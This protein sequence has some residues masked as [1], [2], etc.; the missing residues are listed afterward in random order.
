[1]PEEPAPE[2][3]D[4]L[5][6]LQ[7][8]DTA[9][10]RLHHQL[11][12][13]PEQQALDEA[14]QRLADLD[15][16]HTEARL[17]LEQAEAPVKK[18]EGEVS[19][20][21][22]RRDDDQSRLYSGQISNPREL[23]SLRAEIDSTQRRISDHED[24]LL[25]AMEHREEAQRRFDEL[26]AQRDELAAEV[27]RLRDERD[28]AAK[29]L[30]AERAEA[31]TRRDAE[32]EQLSADVLEQYERSARR[33]PGLAVATLDGYTCTGCRIDLPRVEVSKLRA[34]PALTSCPECG[35]LMVV[36]S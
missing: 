20:L 19:M 31:E 36:R 25:E 34:G 6:A 17:E 11:E 13:L 30:L 14:E 15:R 24:Q 23:Q 28:A 1:M 21:E 10:R 16:R 33:F 29:G 8:A 35:R 18:L 22:Q 26:T 5:L 7:E 27:E 12:T 9:V 4:H 3:L 2:Q 32:R